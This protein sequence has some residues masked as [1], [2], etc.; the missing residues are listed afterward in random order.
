MKKISVIFLNFVYLISGLLVLEVF[1]GGWLSSNSLGQLNI[2]KNVEYHFNT[3]HL[4]RG[5]FPETLY[6][7]DRFGLRGHYEDPDHIDILTV[8]G[9]ATD[10]RYLTEGTTWQ[11]VIEKRFLSDEKKVKIANAGVDGQSS[12]GHLKNFELWFP[13]IPHLKPRYVLLYLGVNDLLTQT[14]ND[15][16]AGD[17]TWKGR[18]RS[19]SALFHLYE[20]VKGNYLSLFHYPLGHQSVNFSHLHWTSH[21]LQN[22][23]EGL[24][25]HRLEAHEKNLS[26]LN[27]KIRALGAIPIYVTQPSFLYRHIN[28]VVE[29]AETVFF[30]EGLPINGI[31]FYNMLSLI[32]ERTLQVCHDVHGICLNLAGEVSFE[33]TD[34]YDYFHN[35]PEGAQKI[36][37]YLYKKLKD[38]L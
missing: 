38:V 14:S 23:H 31:D 9:S 27:K 12:Y 26:Q 30:Y 36:G 10:Q 5:K 18:I 21:P 7:R 22:N 8:G 19:K 15:D 32:N 20:L 13:K 16:L 1:F 2:L 3:S 11:D 37:E 28:S 29:G 33:E 17:Q 6:Q 25:A 24:L 34:F 4:Y 35:T